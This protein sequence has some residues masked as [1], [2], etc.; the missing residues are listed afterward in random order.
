MRMLHNKEGGTIP[1]VTSHCMGVWEV[2][3][4]SFSIGY[5]LSLIII[6]RIKIVLN[7]YAI[8][9]LALMPFTLPQNGNLFSKAPVLLT[10]F[11]K[12]IEQ[13]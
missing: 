2:K 1:S 5:I 12:S 6:S 10:T 4:T 11:P 13:S 8:Y 9:A 7:T 3:M